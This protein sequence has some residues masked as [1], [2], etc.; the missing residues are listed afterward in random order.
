MAP[1]GFNNT[2]IHRVL[3]QLCT[4][5]PP[6]QQQDDEPEPKEGE[7]ARSRQ[8]LRVVAYFSIA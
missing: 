8:R 4:V 3:G 2:R 1:E 6:L 5:T 7:E